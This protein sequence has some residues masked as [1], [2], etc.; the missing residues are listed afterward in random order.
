MDVHHADGPLQREARISDACTLVLPIPG[1][2]PIL[3][4]QPAGRPGTLVPVADPDRFGPW[5]TRR[6]WRAWVAAFVASAQDT[7]S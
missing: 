7:P 3:A 5:T 1:G 4:M 6:E 2:R